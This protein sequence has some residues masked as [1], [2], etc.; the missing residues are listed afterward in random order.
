MST[1]SLKLPESLL[2]RLEQESRAR[3][4]TKSAVVRAALERELE[5]AKSACATSCY[6]LARDLAGSVRKKLPKDL[7]TH[8]KYMEGFGR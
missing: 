5:L 3:R 6:D 4:L 1:F 7:A 2:L 8:S